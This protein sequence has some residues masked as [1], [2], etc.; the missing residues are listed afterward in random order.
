M[1]GASKIKET[2]T[3]SKAI[4]L[5]YHPCYSSFLILSHSTGASWN[6][7]SS[8]AREVEAHLLC[9]RRLEASG[10]DSNLVRHKKAGV[11]PDTELTN[12]RHVCITLKDR[13]KCSNAWMG[14]GRGKGVGTQDS[15]VM[16]L[17]RFMPREE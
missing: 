11:K 16:L 2:T 17:K 6:Q 1:Y 14:G 13:T 5:T 3:S 7:T 15:H 10:I 8:T 12:Q 4:R 9:I